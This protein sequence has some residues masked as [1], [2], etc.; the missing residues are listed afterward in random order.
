MSGEL[1]FL[2]VGGLELANS[3][4]TRSYLSRGLAGHPKWEMGGAALGCS[5]LAREIGGVGPFVSP[6]ADPAP[7]YDSTIPE[8]AEFLG[9]YVTSLDFSTIDVRRNVSQR[10]GGVGGGVIGFEQLGARGVYVKAWLI[11]SSCAGMEYGRHWVYSRL[12]ADCA[13]CALGTLRV[14]ES[15]PPTDGLNDTRGERLIY[16]AA[17]VNGISRTASDSPGWPC[18]DFDPIEFTLAGQSPYLYSRPGVGSAAVNFQSS[19]SSVFP[20]VV[21]GGIAPVP[22]ALLDSGTRANTGP[23]PSAS[24]TNTPSSGFGAQLKII[25]NQFAVTPGA[26]NGGAYWNAG[27]YA[28]DQAVM[29]TYATR[30]DNFGA[31]MWLLGR[32]TTPG[33][34]TGTC[35]FMK[36]AF[37]ATGD[38]IT[39]GRVLASGQQVLTFGVPTNVTAVVGD[40]YML[41]CRGNVIEAWRLPSGGAWVHLGAFY[42]PVTPTAG[43]IGLAISEAGTSAGATN[44]SGGA[45]TNGAL[46]PKEPLTFPMPA[47]SVGIVSPVVTVVQAGYGSIS[48][49]NSSNEVR[50]QLKTGSVDCY[51]SDDFA[52][53]DLAARWTQS[54]AG[55]WQI[56]GGKLKPT[57]T[58]ALSSSGRRIQRSKDSTG[59]A[60]AFYGGRIQATIKTAGVVANGVWG[61]QLG[62][63]GAFL[64]QASPGAA[65]GPNT[66]TLSNDANGANQGDS[67]SFTPVISTTY[68]I[69]CEM[70]PL[71]PGPGYELR[72]YLVDPATNAMLTRPLTANVATVNLMAAPFLPGI[73]SIP[74]ST[75]EEWDNFYAIDYS[76]SANYIEIGAPG[77]TVVLDASRRVSRYTTTGGVSKDASAY[78]SS[79]E[80]K[81][82]GWVDLCAG[83][84]PGCLQVW[85]AET[86]LYSHTVSV[87][88]QQRQ[89]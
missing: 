20:P 88:F 9:L 8:S 69:I 11:A 41:T 17:L 4:R 51:Q 37:G 19:G 21:P 80:G 62:A 25:G 64:V 65:I 53:D 89:R 82:L 26:V 35:V 16:D 77:G 44:F 46:F 54:H 40:K 50:V 36:L 18:C 12:G 28:A 84:G 57:V 76:D 49:Q 1:S 81:P 14:R 24:W 59:K 60:I 68:L 15:C 38:F 79:K 29:A 85:G 27:T 87:A 72:G 70:F 55:D 3:Y 71:D 22:P 30:G 42:D 61:L 83:Q 34:G 86:S 73:N 56:T 48:Q 78:L 75:S 47:V 33:S 2:D 66:F 74:A 23:P 63:Y 39:M 52:A 7:W 32:I 43:Y 31:G 13:G 5:V 6:S 10:F 67:V 45:L 58:G